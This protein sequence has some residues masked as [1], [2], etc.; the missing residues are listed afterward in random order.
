MR[1]GAPLGKSK[2]D[3]LGETCIEFSPTKKSRATEGVRRKKK[4]SQKEKDGF[5]SAIKYALRNK[6]NQRQDDGSYAES[7][8]NSEYKFP[9]IRRDV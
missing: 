7:D 3:V 4:V 2:C 9:A 6:V 1:G 5:R 8:R